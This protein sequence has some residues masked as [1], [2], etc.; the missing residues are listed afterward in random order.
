MS[1]HAGPPGPPTG[2]TAL[3][4]DLEELLLTWTAPFTLEGVHTN[5]ALT[6]NNTD[7]AGDA[8]VISLNATTYAFQTKGSSCDVYQFHVRASNAAGVSSTT[9]PVNAAVP[10]CTSVISTCPNYFSDHPILY[11]YVPDPE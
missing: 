3:P 1:C 5:Y 6:I 4:G 8:Q 10:A 7:S 2:L 11:D 9:E